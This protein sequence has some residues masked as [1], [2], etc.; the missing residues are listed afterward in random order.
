LDVQWK[1]HEDLCG[2]D[3]H[4]ITIFY[5]VVNTS[6]ATPSWKLSRADWD[7]F[8]ECASIHLGID[9][10]VISVED[11]SKN[12]VDIATYTIPRNKPSVR[13]RN[14]IWFNNQFKEARSNRKKACEKL[15]L[16]PQRTIFNATK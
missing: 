12:L 2:S 8:A 7:H 1:A 6:Y 11:V 5:D 10:S 4:P 9:N 16:T 3:R 14:T 15:S 13:E